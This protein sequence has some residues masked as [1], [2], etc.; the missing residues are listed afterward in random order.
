MPAHIKDFA[1]KV[2]QRAGQIIVI[3]AVGPDDKGVIGTQ[4]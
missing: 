2:A 4:T 3:T 1:S